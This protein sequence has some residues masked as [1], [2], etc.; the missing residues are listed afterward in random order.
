VEVPWSLKHQE[1]VEKYTCSAEGSYIYR[2]QK[3]QNLFEIEE[4]SVIEAC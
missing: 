2:T 4:D 1:A 3:R